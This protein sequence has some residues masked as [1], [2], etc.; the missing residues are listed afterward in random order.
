MSMLNVS[1]IGCA[2]L[3]CASALPLCAQWTPLTPLSR[4]GAIGSPGGTHPVVADGKTVHAVWAQ[5]G[6]IHYRRS[7]NCGVTWG[8]TIQLTSS[9]EA[10]YPCSL[11]LSG[12]TL[13][14]IW[15]DSRNGT[16][17]IYYKCSMDGG[18]TW[19]TDMR[20][21]P[22]VD[23]FRPGTAISGSTIHVVWGS[24]SLILPTPAGTHTWGEI[25]YM[26]STDAG[27]TWE[28]NVRLTLPDD[29]AM[30]PSIAASG[31]YVHL[32]WFD[33]RDSKKIWDW[34]IY[35]KRST[36]GG[37]TWEPDVRMSHTPWHARHPQIV[38]TP[39]GR[40]CCI[41]EDGQTFD[42][43]R[44]LGDPGLYA[45]VSKDNGETWTKPQ[46]ITFINAPNGWAT[47]AKSYAYGSRIHL[48]WTDAPEGTNHPH[49]AYY[50]T[51]P[52]GGLTW[53]NPE[54]LT[55]ASDGSWWASAVGGTGAYVVELMRTSDIIYYRRRDVM[56]LP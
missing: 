42:G 56:A 18:K 21:T 54:R 24:K 33:R 15:P 1:L 46:R 51:S 6:K 8:H 36:D 28:R 48:A 7:T 50:M 19:G 53:E 4:G 23:L 49:A 22:G 43:V 14:L 55:L 37:A 17:E 3:L 13:H 27:K 20:L 39:Q 34:D 52:D 32:T 5:G 12:S 41:W 35:Y 29:S 40:V 44:W 31:E 26:R 45:S 38:A 25:Y 2:S 9:G 47:H 30:R 11:E 16:W 10:Q